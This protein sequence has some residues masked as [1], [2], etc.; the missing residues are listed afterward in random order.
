MASNGTDVERVVLEHGLDGTNFRSWKFHVMAILRG[1]GL[2]SVVDGS[3]PKPDALADEK[4]KEGWS[5]K[6]AKAIAILF[7]RRR[8]IRGFLFFTV[9][10]IGK[11]Y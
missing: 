2:L 3:S 8:R 11:W 7:S 5:Q 10:H 6:D 4:V 9:K 1:K